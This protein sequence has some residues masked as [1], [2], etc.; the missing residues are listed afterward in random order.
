MAFLALWLLV[1]IILAILFGAMFPKDDT[2]ADDDEPYGDPVG[3]D[4]T[5]SQGKR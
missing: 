3:Y 2:P 5:P 4:R 1:A